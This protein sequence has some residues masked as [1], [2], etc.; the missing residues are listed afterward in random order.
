MYSSP[1]KLPSTQPNPQATTVPCDFPRPLTHSFAHAF[2]ADAD[3]AWAASPASPSHRPGSQPQACRKVCSG[4]SAAA[5]CHSPPRPRHLPIATYQPRCLPPPG[6]EGLCDRPLCTS[7]RRG[8]HL[9]P[10][11]P[12]GQSPIT[13]AR[14]PESPLAGAAEPAC[15][16]S[17]VYSFFPAASPAG[18]TASRVSQRGNVSA[19]MGVG[20]PAPQ[21]P[22]VV[23]G[24]RDDSVGC[25]TC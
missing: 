19:A 6:G 18:M 1:R 5:G 14:L 12:P 11:P 4:A 10:P 13:L 9:A 15:V 7:C 20:M 8:S 21:C 16:T 25:G 3:A 24:E 23:L 22:G 2:V 17:R